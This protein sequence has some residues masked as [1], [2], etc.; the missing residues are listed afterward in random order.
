M[1]WR[2]LPD[3]SYL[4]TVT[5]SLSGFDEKREAA[6]KMIAL[7]SKIGPAAQPLPKQRMSVINGPNGP[8]SVLTPQSKLLA[9]D[10]FELG[11]GALTSETG[12]KVALIGGIVAAAWLVTK[13][14][15]SGK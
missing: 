15:G 10:P 2:Q 12:K 13:V 7:R 11:M 5:G 1:T 14:T 6:G 8:Q 9:V 3:G 4:N